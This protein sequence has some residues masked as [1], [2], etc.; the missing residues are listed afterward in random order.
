MCVLNHLLLVLL[1]SIMGKKYN[2][3]MKAYINSFRLR[4]LPLSMSGI[5]LG[6]F[7]SPNV[8]RW[9]VFLFAIL[10]VLCLQILTNLCN[11]LGDAR[12]GTD[13]EQSGRVAYSLQQGLITEE[14]LKRCIYIFSVLAA[15][16]GTILVWLTFGTLFCT[17]SYVFLALGA[18]AIVAAITYTLG[19]HAYGYHGF[20]DVSVFLFFG[21]LSVIGAYY[22]QCRTWNW[23]I[24]APACTVGLLSVGVL[25]LNNIRDMSNDVEHGKFTLASY[26]GVKAAKY[27]QSVIVLIAPLFMLV[28]PIYSSLLALPVMACHVRYLWKHNGSDLDKYMPIIVFTTLL[29]SIFA[30]IEWCVFV[31]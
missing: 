17:E 20:G 16:M 12:R 25:N 21:L 5:I 6:T 30:S 31:K 1:Q 8:I 2:K 3:F 22:L 19:S 9:E 18:A 29:L 10:T 28:I 24:I 11:E 4:T 14:G 26:L 15:I 13:T 23:M 27:M 7:L